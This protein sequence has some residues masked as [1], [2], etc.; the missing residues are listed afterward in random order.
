MW[1]LT[2]LQLLPQCQVEGPVALANGRRH[3]ALQPDAVFL[4]APSKARQ[5]CKL[6]CSSKRGTRTLV[7]CN[8]ATSDVAACES[9]LACSKCYACKLLHLRIMQSAGESAASVMASKEN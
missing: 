9:K 2:H 6:P 1:P 7:C 4:Q 8:G 3:G 5:W